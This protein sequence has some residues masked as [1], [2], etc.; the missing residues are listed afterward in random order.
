[1][2]LD[3]YTVRAVISGPSVVFVS[4]KEITTLAPE[5][6]AGAICRKLGFR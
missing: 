3:R 4:V 5:L 2:Q 1:M 6:T